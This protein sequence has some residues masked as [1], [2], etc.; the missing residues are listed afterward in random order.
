MI[1]SWVGVTSFVYISVYTLALIPARIHPVCM[2][3][4]TMAD[5]NHGSLQLPPPST[6]LVIIYSVSI[7]LAMDRSRPIY[8]VMV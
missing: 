3:H 5:Y 1:N 4:I 2:N 8:I 7:E 6:L